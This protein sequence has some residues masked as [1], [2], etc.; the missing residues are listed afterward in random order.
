MKGLKK[1]SMTK[2]ENFFEE[3]NTLNKIGKVLNAQRIKD[4]AI[5]MET[6]E[7]KIQT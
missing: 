3:L 2:V 6:D 4:G 5:L 7:V 1:F